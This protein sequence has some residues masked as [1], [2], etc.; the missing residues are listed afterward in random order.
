MGRPNRTTLTVRPGEAPQAAM[1]FFAASGLPSTVYLYRVP[2]CVHRSRTGYLVV[3]RRRLAALATRTRS[4][5]NQ[6]ARRAT[7][8]LQSCGCSDLGRYRLTPPRSANLLRVEGYSARCTF[9]SHDT[10]HGHTQKQNNM[11]TPL[12]PAITA[13]FVAH[14][15]AG[16]TRLLTRPHR[17]LPTW[18]PPPPAS[19]PG[20]RT[21][22]S[23]AHSQP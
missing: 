16:A 17:H 5:L 12:S 8:T 23:A 22:I 2:Y 4:D 7:C 15:A 18:P 6:R 21:W 11:A 3:S 10:G 20:R 1:D 14:D 13:L 19:A 9:T